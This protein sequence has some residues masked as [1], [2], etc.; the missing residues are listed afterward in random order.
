MQGSAVERG[1]RCFP[2]PAN[3]ATTHITRLTAP[4]D[5]ERRVRDEP[6]VANGWTSGRSP[7]STS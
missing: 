3:A 2:L 1:P 4:I 5:R 7:H 6:G